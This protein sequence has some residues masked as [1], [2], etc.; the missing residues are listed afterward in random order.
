MKNINW[1]LVVG[2][3]ASLSFVG[4]AAWEQYEGPKLTLV[5][6]LVVVRDSC[7]AIAG[8]FLRHVLGNFMP[9]KGG[10]GTTLP[11]ASTNP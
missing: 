5:H 1:G 10:T 9:P 8:F 4:I 6:D 7:L 3:L 11:P 2:L